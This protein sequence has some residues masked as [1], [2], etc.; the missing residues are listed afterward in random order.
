M[1]GSENR[2]G[3]YFRVREPAH[4]PEIE[5]DFGKVMRKSKFYSVLCAPKRARGAVGKR[6]NPPFA[7]RH[8]LN[9]GMP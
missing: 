9:I 3:A 1:A 2:S 6:R 7:G 5:I 4:D 8:H